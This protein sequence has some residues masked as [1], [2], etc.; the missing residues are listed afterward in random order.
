MKFKLPLLLTAIM[1]ATAIFTVE[2]E[3]R[4]SILGDSYSTFKGFVQPEINTCWYFSQQDTT[5]TDVQSVRQTWWHRLLKDKGFLLERNN[6]FSGSTISTSGY[7]GEDFTD[8]S[9]TTR[10]CDLGSPDI[11]L[12]FGATNDSWA[13]API[14]EFKY[15]GITRDD[16]KSFRPALA[17]LL[18]TAIDRYPNARIYY[19]VWDGI[20]PELINSAEEISRHYAVPFLVIRDIEVKNGHPTVK[21]M[22][23][24]TRQVESFISE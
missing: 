15:N 2:A 21:G 7:F 10:V 1:A 20:K 16:L 3:K 19:M 14:G 13:D 8:R 18:E 12:I 5:R 11:I 22:Q 23:S 9:F 17:Y 4:V 6:S 24:I